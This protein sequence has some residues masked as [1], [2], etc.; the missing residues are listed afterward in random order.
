METP[1][2]PKMTPELFTNLIKNVKPVTIHGFIPKTPGI[3]KDNKSDEPIAEPKE[4]LE[5]DLNDVGLKWFS[6]APMYCALGPNFNLLSD[7]ANTSE[8]KEAHIAS[9][10]VPYVIMPSL[11]EG[12]NVVDGISAEHWPYLRYF[13]AESGFSKGDKWWLITE[14][15]FEVKQPK[16]NTT[17]SLSVFTPVSVD[18]GVYSYQDVSDG[19]IK[20]YQG[21]GNPLVAEYAKRYNMSVKGVV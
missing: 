8:G 14:N 21:A 6:L 10:K 4:F 9:F 5:H 12:T 17:V 7:F 11:E 13:L 15:V 18:L 1:N 20:F 2:F 16:H 3:T 19:S